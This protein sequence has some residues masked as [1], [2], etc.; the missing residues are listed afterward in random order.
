MTFQFFVVYHFKPE[1]PKIVEISSVH[2]T[3][4]FYS[5]SHG[6]VSGFY[7]SLAIFV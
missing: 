3:S 7:E 2:T 6:G 1:T 4:T 5:L